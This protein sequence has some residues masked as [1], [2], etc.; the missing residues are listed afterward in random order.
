[1]NNC[2]KPTELSSRIDAPQFYIIGAS[3]TAR[4][5]FTNF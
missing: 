2:Q 1:M 5:D 3:E 4:E